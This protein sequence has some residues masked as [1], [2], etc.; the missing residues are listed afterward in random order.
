M[1]G[2]EGEFGKFEIRIGGW[3]GGESV[4]FGIEIERD[5]GKWNFE[6]KL[7]TLD[8]GELMEEWNE[9]TNWR[10]EGT[11]VLPTYGRN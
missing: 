6:K 7:V 1:E 10:E 3:G 11:T 8:I 5:K 9:E 4:D 2:V